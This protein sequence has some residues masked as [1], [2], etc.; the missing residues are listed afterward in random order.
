[1]RFMLGDHISVLQKGG[2]GV[3]LGFGDRAFPESGAEAE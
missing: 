1:L 3:Q 2:V